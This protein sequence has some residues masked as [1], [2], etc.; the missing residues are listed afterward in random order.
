MLRRLVRVVL[1]VAVLYVGA[2]VGFPYYQYVMMK[3]AVEEA[4]DVG[5]AKLRAMRKERW[6]AKARSDEVTPAVTVLMHARAIRLGLDPPALA[7]QVLLEQDF[8]RILADWEAEAR[9]PGY[10][11]RFR[12]RV[13]GRR[14]LAN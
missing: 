4:A 10:V 5:V 12:F 2:T 1:L 14:I 6:G 11:Q 3:R 13:E 9:L 8:L 7:I